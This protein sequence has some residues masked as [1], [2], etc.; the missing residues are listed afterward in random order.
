MPNIG[1]PVNKL[2]WPF[3]FYEVDQQLECGMQ[4]DF[5]LVVPPTSSQGVDLEFY[6]SLIR[7]ETKL[8][9]DTCRG[10]PSI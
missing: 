5:I 10:Q 1:A 6:H 4:Q 3:L 7:S 9:R 2:R 8:Y